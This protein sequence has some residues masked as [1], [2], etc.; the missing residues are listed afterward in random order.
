[1]AEDLLRGADQLATAERLFKASDTERQ[2][3]RG[4]RSSSRDTQCRS[5]L[6]RRQDTQIGPA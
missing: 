6:R 4:A 5:Y 1:V 3:T 2:R